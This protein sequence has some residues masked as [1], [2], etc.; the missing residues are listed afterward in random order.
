MTCGIAIEINSSRVIPRCYQL[1]G[2]RGTTGID[3]GP[4]ST[5]RPNTKRRKTQRA[6][7]GA[8]L[9]V[10]QL[11]RLCYLAADFRVP[12][13]NVKEQDNQ[14]MKWNQPANLTYKR[15]FR[16]P[17]SWFEGGNYRQPSPS[18][19][20]SSND[21]END[22]IFSPEHQLISRHCS[23]TYH[24]ASHSIKPGAVIDLS[25]LIDVHVVITWAQCQQFSIR[26]QFHHLQS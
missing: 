2:M 10:S 7:V 13:D 22:W 20:W 9:Q 16:D 3:V 21:P 18:A 4:I 17:P 8:P 12:W 15:G 11:R 1:L 26:R 6:G 25:D 24:T 23:T 5:F 19:L 14:H